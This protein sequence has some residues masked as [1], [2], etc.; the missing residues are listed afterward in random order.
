MLSHLVCAPAPQRNIVHSLPLPAGNMNVISNL[1]DHRF[2]RKVSLLLQWQYMR[3][4]VLDMASRV[5]FS[6]AHEIFPLISKCL[7]KDSLH[8]FYTDY[9]LSCPHQPIWKA[10]KNRKYSFVYRLF[11]KLEHVFPIFS[12]YICHPDKYI[13]NAQ[14]HRFSAVLP[15]ASA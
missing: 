7:A 11:Y 1:V 12:K 9:Y 2:N 8:L 3:N 14:L 13:R 5:K 6:T 4:N 10:G 15:E